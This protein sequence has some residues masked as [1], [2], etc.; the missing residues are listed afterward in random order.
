MRK[1]FRE[2]YEAVHDMGFLIQIFS[3]GSL[4][5]KETVKWLKM[6]PPRAVRFT[7][8][9]VCDETYGKV[10]GAE[11][12]FSRV[13]NSI[14]IL[15]NVGIPLYLCATI[16]KENECELEEMYR[17]AADQGLPLIHTA[18]LVNPVR[19]AT[20]DAKCH[21]VEYRIP[22][23]EVIR[24]IREQNNGKYPRKPCKNYFQ[25]CGNYRMGFWITWNGMLQLCAFL[26]EPAVTVRDGDFMENWQQLQKKLDDLRQPEECNNC[27]YERYCQ[28]CPGLLYA[29]NGGCD[30]VSE[31]FCRKA[32]YRYLLLEKE[33]SEDD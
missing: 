33:I 25:F 9:G 23:P 8:Y 31:E 32:Q 3:N 18:E 6:R 22:P 19:G 30:R 12:G 27:R 28:R 1:D 20:S 26:T 10:C 13:K 7:L 15:K 29:E 17:F 5:D 4:I 2:I 11:D 21:Q 14:E 24:S 16:T